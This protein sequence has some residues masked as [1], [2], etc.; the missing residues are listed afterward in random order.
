MGQ[1][2]I[3]FI[4]DQK[5]TSDI[6]GHLFMAYGK[7]IEEILDLIFLWLYVLILT[8]RV[9]PSSNSRV[10]SLNCSC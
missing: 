9:D 1:K 8:L 7:L 2:Y 6:M 3:M 4:S 5:C 10:K